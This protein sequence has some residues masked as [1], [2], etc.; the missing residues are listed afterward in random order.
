MQ[1]SPSSELAELMRRQIAMVNEMN[2]IIRV[3][4]WEVT[5]LR[6]KCESAVN[7]A[8][9]NVDVHP[10][11]LSKLNEKLRNLHASYACQVEGLC[12]RQR[13]EFR[14]LVD[15]LYEGGSI[16]DIPTSVDKGAFSRSPQTKSDRRQEEETFSDA[17]NESYTIYI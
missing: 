5:Q 15:V 12:E 1:N 17:L 7:D 4:N 3:R 11:E 9:A 13:K 6:N 2:Q 8:S 16:L 14:D 10:H